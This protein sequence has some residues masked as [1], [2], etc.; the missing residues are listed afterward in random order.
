[1]QNEAELAGVLGH[2]IIHIT[3]Q[4]TIRAI[5][6]NKTIQMG[7]DETLSG[8]AALLNRS[9]KTS[10]S[11]SS[12]RASAARKRTRATRRASCSPTRW[13]RAQG[14]AFLTRLQERNKDSKEKRGL[15][16]S[17]P[18]MK[19]RLDR[20]TKQIASAKLTATA[21][22]A[23][24]YK[25]NITFK[26]VAHTRLRRGRGAGLAGAARQR[27]REA[28]RK[29]GRDER[30][31][32]PKKEGLCGSGHAANR[33][34]RAEVGA[35]ERVRAA[36]EEW[37]PRGMPK[38]DQSQA[39]AGESRGRGLRRVQE[40]RRAGLSVSFEHGLHD[41]SLIA[42]V[43]ALV[44]TLALAGVARQPSQPLRS[45][46]AAY[47]TLAARSRFSSSR[48]PSMQ[49]VGDVAVLGGACAARFVL[50]DQSVITLP[51]QP[52]ARGPSVRTVSRRSSRTSRS[53]ACS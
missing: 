33:W 38:A 16:A 46:A 45:R 25:K 32:H 2:E 7:A 10:I 42:G 1:M 40:R 35:G 3:E 49:S 21:T 31:S 18:E 4:H 22:L 52:V 36:L 39:G 11:I 19:E 6:K 48:S 17:H 15:F 27:N 12:T 14:S 44:L 34:R 51:R 20:L 8:N 24:R 13:L 26:P 41:P 29:S 50:G 53:S 28:R 43:V 5:Q 23:D 30:R 37:I 47:S 9:P